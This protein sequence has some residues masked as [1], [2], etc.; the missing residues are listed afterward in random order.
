[1]KKL[2]L[3]LLYAILLALLFP[4]PA[5]ALGIQEPLP[6]EFPPAFGIALTGLLTYLL[7]HALQ[8]RFPWITGNLA[9][10]ASALSAAFVSL[11]TGLVNLYVPVEFTPILTQALLLLAA[12][13]TG[14]GIKQLEKRM[15][16][17]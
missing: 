13:M 1:M 5:L 10:L 2:V 8:N 16:K 12:W 4:Q 11:M 15:L 17:A 6:Y 3:V 9:L 14:V 7:T